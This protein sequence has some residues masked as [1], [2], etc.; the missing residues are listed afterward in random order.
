MFVFDQPKVKGV[1]DLKVSAA[2]TMTTDDEVVEVPKFCTRFT[3]VVTF[4]ETI[5]P[6]YIVML[7]ELTFTFKSTT[8]I[9]MFS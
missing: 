3:I 8:M 4:T 2:R 9:R 6:H 5:P 7:S 1:Y